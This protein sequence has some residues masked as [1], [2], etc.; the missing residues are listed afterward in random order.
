MFAH[1]R[2]LVVAAGAAATIGAGALV[3]RPASADQT[4]TALLTAA[5]IVGAIVYSNVQRKHAQANQVVGYTNNGGTVYGDG[6]VVMP[7]GQTYYPDANGN[8]AYN[9]NG[10]YNNGQYNNGQYD[11]GQYNN[12]QYNT[13]YNTNGQYQGQPYSNG[14]Y[15]NGRGNGYGDNKPV[16]GRWN[17]AEG[18]RG[19]VAANRGDEKSRGDH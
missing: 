19:N 17:G 6:R 13:G 3:P 8:Y 9:G 1:L 12:G 18:R 7:N 16:N 10:Q 4:S 2:K 15:N 5:A 14:Q 11:N